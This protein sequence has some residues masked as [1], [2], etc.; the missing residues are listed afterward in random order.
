MC[1]R[2]RSTIPNKIIF[3]K[4]GRDQKNDDWAIFEQICKFE[5]SNEDNDSD[6][7]SILHEWAE[8]GG[9]DHK[10]G[11]MTYPNARAQ[12]IEGLDIYMNSNSGCAVYAFEVP[13]SLEFDKVPFALGSIGWQDLDKFLTNFRVYGAKRRFASFI[14][15]SLIH[16]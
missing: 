7:A 8:N 5:L 6:Y 4:I 15:L 1:I 9:P 3:H 10:G 13:N 16:I 11:G 14:M 12:G 2:D